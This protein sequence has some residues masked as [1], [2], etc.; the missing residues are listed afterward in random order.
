MLARLQQS[1]VLTFVGL[2]VAWLA[3][4]SRMGWP[5]VL[6]AA[7]VIAL[8]LPHAWVLALEFVALRS[9]EPGDGIP[10]PTTG[11]LAMAWWGEVR[12]GLRVFGW[13]QPFRSGRYADLLPSGH[14]TPRRGVVLVHGF[15]CNRGLWNP[16]MQ[17]LRAAGVPHAAVNMEPVFGSIDAYTAIIERAVLAVH[18]ASGLPPLIVS[19]SMGGLAVRAWLRDFAADGRVDSI[20][21]IGSPHDGTWLARF[22]MTPNT[23]QMRRHGPW[24]AALADAE[25]PARRALFTCFYSHCDNIV[26]PAS[27]G[28]LDG[29]DNR[30]LP[31]VAHVQQVFQPAVWSEVA[32]RLDIDSGAG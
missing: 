8:A 14:I 27:T 13:Q 26:F 1:L 4:S 3:W 30:H 24:L 12:T 18:A 9:V 29:A 7:G 15:V 31:G 19:H 2:L 11:Q 20:I 17:R 21:T 25:T 32:R 6:V 5:Q 23:R 10:K 16:W 28:M 22:A